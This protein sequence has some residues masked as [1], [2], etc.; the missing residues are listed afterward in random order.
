MLDGCGQPF[1]DRRPAVA[2][3]GILSSY[4]RDAAPGAQRLELFRTGM[5]ELGWTEGQNVQYHVRYVDDGPFS[6]LAAQLVRLPVD[7][8]FTIGGGDNATLAAR[9]ASSS[10]PIVFTNLLDPVATG[11][12]ASL[13]HPGGN[14]TGLVFPP[15]QDP[16]NV[17]LLK[18]VVPE[19]ARLA[20]LFYPASPA[21]TAESVVSGIE[22]AAATAGIQTRRVEVQS[23]DDFESAFARAGA[24]PAQALFVV[25]GPTLINPHYTL[26]ADLAV[27]SRLPSITPV[28]G[29]AEAGGLMT[30]GPKIPALYTGAASYVDRILRGAKPSDLPVEQPTVYDFVVNLK[31]ARTL[32]ILFPPDV[33]AQVT[34][35]IE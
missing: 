22:Q 29:Y 30:Y 9:D 24:W 19:L 21:G 20:I 10:I 33:A 31:T 4:P 1:W 6:E 15:S 23:A 5:R 13:A 14:I 11:L 27:H 16:K 7:V 35:W 12:V 18:A 2:R 25:S 26:I 28:R 32:G 8:M 3:V 34:E 17:E